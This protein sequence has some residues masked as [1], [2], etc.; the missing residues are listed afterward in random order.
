MRIDHVLNTTYNQLGQLRVDRLER[1]QLKPDR[2]VRNDDQ[3]NL[4]MASLEADNGFLS[5]L[6]L[7]LIKELEEQGVLDEE[8]L[9][10]QMEKLDRLDGRQ[11]HRLAPDSLRREIEHPDT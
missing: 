10:R 3:P 7:A 5:L 1:A 6:V 2:H 4:R 11:D 8:K 9:V